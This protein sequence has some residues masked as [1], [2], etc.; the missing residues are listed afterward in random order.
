MQVPIPELRSR[1]EALGNACQVGV[2]RLPALIAGNPALLLIAH[3][4][5][6]K[7]LDAF[8]K[9]TGLSLEQATAMVS[10]YMFR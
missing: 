1:M 4:P 5:L 8:K 7:K 3:E 2:V 6:V 10:L 9:A